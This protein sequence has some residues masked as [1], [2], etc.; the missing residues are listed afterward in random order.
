M[1]VRP[2]LVAILSLTYLLCLPVLPAYGNDI[3]DG[4]SCINKKITIGTKSQNPSIIKTA[5]K[6]KL[7]AAKAKLSSLKKAKAKASKITAQQAVIAAI[8]LVQ[9]KVRQ[10]ISGQLN[11]PT[12]TPTPTPARTS[13]VGQVNAL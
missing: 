6:T 13:G 5:L 12:P 10:C 8:Q 11:P 7:T 2:V 4:L 9:T 1:R 3:G